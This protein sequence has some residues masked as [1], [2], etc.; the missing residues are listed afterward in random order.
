MILEYMTC[1]EEKIEY[2]KDRPG[3]DFR[4]AIDYSK[5]KKSLSWEPQINF[6]DGLA[7]TIEWYNKN[8]SWWKRVKNGE[9]IKYYKEQYG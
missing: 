9:Y 4:Y 2:V 1:T 8:S 7:D 6:R 3:H 5:A